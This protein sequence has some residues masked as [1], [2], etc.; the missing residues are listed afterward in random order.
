MW[1]EKRIIAEEREEETLTR[2]PVEQWI[3]KKA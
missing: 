1:L 3:M 2:W